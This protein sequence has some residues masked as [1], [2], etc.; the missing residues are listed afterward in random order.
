M[1][2][3]HSAVRQKLYCTA[4]PARS[5]SAPS[6]SACAIVINKEKRMKD[7]TLGWTAAAACSAAICKPQFGQGK[8]LACTEDLLRSDSFPSLCSH[9]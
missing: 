5:P 8:P 9:H 3:F 7:T 1:P 2:E 6:L 4:L